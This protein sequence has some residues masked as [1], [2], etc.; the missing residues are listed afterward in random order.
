[1]LL[2]ETK[3]WEKASKTHS[4]QYSKYSLTSFTNTVQTW[5]FLTKY[6]SG[7]A[8]LVCFGTEW[9]PCTSLTLRLVFDT[10]VK[11]CS[12]RWQTSD[13][14]AQLTLSSP[15]ALLFHDSPNMAAAQSRLSDVFHQTEKLCRVETRRG[16]GGVICHSVMQGL[17]GQ[18]EAW[19]GG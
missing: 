11:A 19:A 9:S 5:L 1:M 6:V 12:R 8:Q 2:N 13:L 16:E 14:F 18:R 15:D 7:N 4:V 17:G 10:W 3:C